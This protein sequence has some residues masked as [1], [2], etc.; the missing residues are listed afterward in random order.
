[1]RM[2]FFEDP[3]DRK[4][5]AAAGLAQAIFML[6]RKHSDIIEIGRVQLGRGFIRDIPLKEGWAE[7]LFAIAQIDWEKESPQVQRLVKEL[8]E[9]LKK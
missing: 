6:M 3:A 1:M 5:L 9:V 8:K 7:M 4:N 2:T